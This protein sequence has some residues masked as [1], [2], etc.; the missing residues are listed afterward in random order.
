MGSYDTGSS[1]GV[2]RLQ[3]EKSLVEL[4]RE[5]IVSSSVISRDD[6]EK[7]DGIKDSLMLSVDTRTIWRTRVEAE[8]SVLNDMKFPTYA[9]KFHQ[10]AREQVVFFDNLHHLSFDYR[11]KLLELEEIDSK[12][13][14]TTPESIE[15]RR[16]EI[17]RDEA[18]YMLSV[19]QHEGRERV[20]EIIMWEEIKQSCLKN[21]PTIHPDD[22]NAD[23]L[24]GHALRYIQELPAA[25]SAKNSPGEAINIISQAIS[26]IKACED[27]GIDLDRKGAEAR[28]LL[29][30]YG[31]A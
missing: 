20:R 7:L 11:R 8:L 1:D 10:S 13:K 21:D 27:A 2:T 29:K 14:D 5:S 9:A 30:K 28:K 3:E 25:L 16:L 17:D 15:A 26:G 6:L 31:W 4:G 19:M 23:Q 18:I 22:K 12:I 24:L